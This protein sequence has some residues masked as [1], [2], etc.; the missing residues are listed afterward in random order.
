MYMYNTIIK[1]SQHSDTTIAA[2]I[3]ICSH[4]DL[5][6]FHLTKPINVF[7]RVLDE[8][9][10]KVAAIWNDAIRKYQRFNIITPELYYIW[11]RVSR[12]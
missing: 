4:R 6:I 9:Y 10:I 11:L 3:A 7:S 12:N 2:F 1:L 5:R 8:Q